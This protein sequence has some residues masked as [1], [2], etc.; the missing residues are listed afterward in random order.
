MNGTQGLDDATK[1]I[2]EKLSNEPAYSTVLY[3]ILV[4]CHPARSSSDVEQKI[5][6]FPEMKGSL[7]S[8]KTFLKWLA[9]VGGI[10][11][12]AAKDEDE[13]PVWHTTAAGQN[14]VKMES[15]GNRF[16]RLLAQEPK[17]KDIYLKVL[18]SCVSPK[19]RTEL[20]SMF[21]GNPILENPLVYPS[22]F[23]ETLERAG[24]LE[25]DEK[26]RTTQ[27]GKDLLKGGV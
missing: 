17:Y 15:Y 27:A 25:W 3:K 26:W 24:G 9:E 13:E 21:S 22:Y 16:E 18:E 12:I 8:S 6:S 23:I 4:Y 5:L 19:S 14:V 7:Q 10:E 1:K 2:L 20:E 11:Q